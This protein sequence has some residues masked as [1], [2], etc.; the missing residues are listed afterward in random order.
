MRHGSAAPPI[1]AADGWIPLTAAGLGTA[2]S[3]GASLPLMRCLS[4]TGLLGWLLNRLP[5]CCGRFASAEV[6]DAAYRQRLRRWRER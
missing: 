1:A 2:P 4:I 3:T 5:P 6:L